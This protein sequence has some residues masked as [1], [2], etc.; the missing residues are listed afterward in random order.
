MWVKHGLYHGSA[1]LAEVSTAAKARLARS[2]TKIS[3]HRAAPLMKTAFFCRFPRYTHPSAGLALS[4]WTMHGVELLDEPL[5]RVRH[6]SP[7]SS[8]SAAD[9]WFLALSPLTAASTTYFLPLPLPLPL[10]AARGATP[11]RTRRASSCAQFSSS[12]NSEETFKQRYRN[13]PVRCPNVSL[14][15][16][17]GAHR[18]GPSRAEL[19]ADHGQMAARDTC[20]PD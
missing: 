6:V 10:R 17:H 2:Y 8:R 13:V 18:P 7:S 12:S 9:F 15:F 5:S 20:G 14:R 16:P 11:R 19:V 3:T 4:G 1:R